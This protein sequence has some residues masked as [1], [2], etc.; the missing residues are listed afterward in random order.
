MYKR[1]IQSILYNYHRLDIMAGSVSDLVLDQ[2]TAGVGNWG[3][4]IG[5]RLGECLNVA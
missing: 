2:P 3:R 1:S 4:I 5:V